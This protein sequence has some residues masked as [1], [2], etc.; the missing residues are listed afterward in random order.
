MV[1]LADRR[2]YEATI[3]LNDARTD[4]AVLR[5]EAGREVPALAFADSDACRWATWCSPSAIRSAS[6]KR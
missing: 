2:E 6:G 3:V 1:A 4:L 5:V